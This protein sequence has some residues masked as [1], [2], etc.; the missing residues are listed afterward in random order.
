MKYNVFV[1]NPNNGYE[2]YQRETDY[3]LNLGK[4]LNDWYDLN[5]VEYVKE[6]KQY[7]YPAA[8]LYIKEAK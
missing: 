8:V 6:M 5:P 1:F 4:E 2:T 3:T 7:F